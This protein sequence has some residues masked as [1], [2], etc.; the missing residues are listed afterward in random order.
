MKQ[1][2]HFLWKKEGSVGVITL[3]RPERTRRSMSWVQ[4]SRRSQIRSALW[5]P[6][7]AM[8]SRSMPG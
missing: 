7:R 6:R 8:N 4:V 2:Q 5:S 3:N 1:P